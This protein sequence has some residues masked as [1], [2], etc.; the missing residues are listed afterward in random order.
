MDIRTPEG[1]Q[2]LG[3]R[4][5]SAI[6]EAGYDSLAAFARKMGVTRGLIHNYVAG[7][8]LPPLDRLQAIADLLTIRAEFGDDL[9]GRYRVKW[10]N[11]KG[12]KLEGL[13]RA[14]QALKIA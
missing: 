12:Q 7:T 13:E 14:G 10:V 3:R 8:T 4:I 6:A 2:E 5:Q 1:K 11:V 9:A